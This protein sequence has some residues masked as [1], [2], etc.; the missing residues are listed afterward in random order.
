M[1]KNYQSTYSPNTAEI[2][3]EMLKEKLNK[4]RQRL[5]KVRAKKAILATGAIERTAN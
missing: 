4:I 3:N 2:K 5:W 1:N